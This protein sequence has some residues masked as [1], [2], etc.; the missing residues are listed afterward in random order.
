[1]LNT[2]PLDISY[3]SDT[4]NV[5]SDFYVPCLENSV[6]YRRAAGYFTSSGL[7]LAAKGIAHLIRNGG[8][9]RL[10]ASPHLTEADLTAIANGYGSRDEILRAALARDV[11][12]AKTEIEKDR[13]AA[14]A[15][16]I[17]NGT[18]DIKL[19]F[20]VE[21]YTRRVQR[22]IYHEK[23]GIFTDAE[24]NRVAFTG[25]QNETVSSALMAQGRQRY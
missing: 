14:L 6:L 5:V 25:S 22:G 2:L 13:L 10:V 11:E 23:I 4:S 9:I 16:L 18:L 12:D 19:A 24:G 3:R 1:M 17:S 21:P 8:H 7:S 20:R 15:W